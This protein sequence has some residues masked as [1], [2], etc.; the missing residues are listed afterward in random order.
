VRREIGN[1]SA[2]GQQAARHDMHGRGG[3][4]IGGRGGVMRGSM[5]GSGFW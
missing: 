3:G 4:M 5:A 1:G 2:D